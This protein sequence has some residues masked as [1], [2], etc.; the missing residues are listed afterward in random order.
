MTQIKVIDVTVRYIEYT[1][2]APCLPFTE[3]R[4]AI[5]FESLPE[6]LQNAPTIKQTCEMVL[7]SICR[8]ESLQSS[9]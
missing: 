7:E 1:N 8:M 9:V 3:V 4:K 5:P 2:Q 6:A